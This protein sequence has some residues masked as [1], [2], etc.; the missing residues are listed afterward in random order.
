MQS[1]E[2]PIVQFAQK[3]SR[4]NIFRQMKFAF[5]VEAQN[6]LKYFWRS[7]KIKFSGLQVVSVTECQYFV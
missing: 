3:I 5:S 1:T 7:V 4:A 2:T 6:I